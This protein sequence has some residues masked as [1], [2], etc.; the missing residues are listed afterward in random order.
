MKTFIAF[1]SLGRRYRRGTTVNS[2]INVKVK[3][4]GWVRMR[5]GELSERTGASARSIRY[6]EQ[7]GLLRSMRLGNGYREFDESA[8]KTVDTIKTLLELGFP[9]ELIQ[10]VLPCTGE[11]GPI[12]QDC[13]VLMQRVAEIRDEMDA[14]ASRLIDTRDA[15]T[16]F[17]A[18]AEREAEGAVELGAA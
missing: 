15:L 4:G 6:Y 14:K 10:R 3:P 9:T 2:D 18:Q 17:L 5:I 12:G 16:S 8:V 13:G 7:I 11:A 1:L